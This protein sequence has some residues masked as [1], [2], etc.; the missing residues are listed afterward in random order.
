VTDPELERLRAAVREAPEDVELRAR[1]AERLLHANHLEEAEDQFKDALRRA[2]DDVGVKLGLAR[3]FHARGKTSAALVVAEDLTRDPA[4]PAAAH[5]LHSRILLQMGDVERAVAEFRRAVARD[6]AADDPDLRARLGIDAAPASDVID[7]RVRAPAGGDD[8]DDDEPIVLERPH[9]TFADI[10]GMDAL[11]EEIQ[12]KIVHPLSHPELYAAYGKKTGGGILLYGPP[13]CG[14]TFLARATA[15]E[16]H[17]AFLPVGLNDVLDMWLGQ[18]ERNLHGVFEEA[19]EHKPCVLFFDEVDA[20]AASRSDFR[21]SAGRQVINQFLS[22][23]DGVQY[24][25]DGVLILAATNAPWHV[26]PG[27]RRP[28]RFDRI[29]FVPPPDALARAA[30]LRLACRG[31]PLADMDYDKLAAKTADF[32]GADLVALVDAAVEEKL[33]RGIRTGLPEPLATKDLLAAAK[34]VRPTTG[35]WFAT[36][37]NYV[38]YANEGGFYDAVRPYLKL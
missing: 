25:N 17:A 6:P 20:L 36:A 9:V 30:I 38:L 18:S 14:K 4:A 10:G 27:F 13:G 31:K 35:D 11:K 28:G 12:L 22:E 2:P 3:V 15:G 34:S 32:S 19:R 26:D 33:R 29:I 24:S 16:V 23:L 1:F 8:G 5:L 7:G 37:R 21:T